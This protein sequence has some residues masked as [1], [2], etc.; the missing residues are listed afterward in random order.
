MNARLVALP[1]RSIHSGSIAYARINAF[2]EFANSAAN[3]PPAAPRQ[4]QNSRHDR[5]SQNTPVTP[6]ASAVT[7]LQIQ[8]NLKPSRINTYAKTGGGWV[9]LLTSFPKR[10]HSSSALISSAFIVTSL[11]RCFVTSPSLPFV[12]SPSRLSV[13]SPSLLFV[14]PPSRL[15]TSL[16][17]CSVT[18]LLSSPRFHILLHLSV[19]SLH[20]SIT[21]AKPYPFLHSDRTPRKNSP[22][23]YTISTKLR[24]RIEIPFV[25][26]MCRKSGPGPSLL[27]LLPCSRLRSFARIS[28]PIHR[29]IHPPVHQRRPRAPKFLSPPTITSNRPDGGPPSPPLPFQ[30][31]SAAPNA[32]SA[33]RRSR[34]PKP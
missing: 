8:K 10:N 7:D 18:L 22:Q 2:S 33:T 15:F 4:F 5:P 9:I 32:R 11:P 23:R 30:N 34:A 14:A 3:R 6:L 1:R 17:L 29:P 16:P 12:T 24:N 13:T 21:S 19:E 25:T 28:P 20:I 26:F 31:L 27:S